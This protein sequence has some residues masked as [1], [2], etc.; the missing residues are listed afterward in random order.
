MQD[1]RYAIRTLR[2][3]AGLHARRGPDAGAR[4]RREYRD[5]QPALSASAAAAALRPRRAAGVRLEH[6]PEDGLAPGER[7]DPRLHRSK[8]AGPGRRRRHAVHRTGGQSGR[9]WAAGTDSRARG[10]AVVLH[11]ARPAAVSRAG[12]HRGRSEA[13]CG[14]VR[15]PDLRA[16]AVAIRRRRL[17]RRPRHPCQR[18]ILSRGRHPAGGFPAAGDGRRRCWCRSRSR[19]SRCPIRGGA[20]SSVR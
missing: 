10:H 20:T 18:R 6:L 15:H 12:V 7:L 19:R 1:I 2:Q 4:D 17:A 16:V 8:D 14:Q 13:G 5:F 11:H 3:A 9:G